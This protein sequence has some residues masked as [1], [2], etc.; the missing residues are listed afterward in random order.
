MMA[1]EGA[2][3]DVL[4]ETRGRINLAWTMGAKAVDF[5]LYFPFL[6]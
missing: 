6:F 3:I 5:T 4:V 1:M 2:G